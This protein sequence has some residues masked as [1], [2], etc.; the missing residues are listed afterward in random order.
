[1]LTVLQD[2]CCIAEPENLIEPMTNIEDEFARAPLLADQERKL[3]DAWASSAA[4]G[5]S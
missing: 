5:S 3:V 1:M 4:V 2:R